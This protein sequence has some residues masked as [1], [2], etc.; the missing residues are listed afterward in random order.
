MN[1]GVA[2]VP[3]L[4]EPGPLVAEIM[5]K[6]G[7]SS[8]W[9]R[10]DP[11]LD[12]LLKAFLLIVI[13]AQ[14]AFAAFPKLQLIAST[15][16]QLVTSDHHRIAA[17]VDSRSG[18]YQTEE[19]AVTGIVERIGT[20]DAFA[21]GVLH[22]WLEQGDERAMAEAGLALTALKHTVPGDMCRLSRAA[23]DDFSASG[24]DVRR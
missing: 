15:A 18:T 20:G 7:A 4:Q 19:I 2:M 8:G 9:A 13:L 1:R 24:G 12:R 22:A 3:V 14:A 23:L 16:R 6:L 11:I 17:R 10:H 21:A 5:P